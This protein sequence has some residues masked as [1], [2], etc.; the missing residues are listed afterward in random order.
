[1]LVYSDLIRLLVSKVILAFVAMKAFCQ[2]F[3]LN[4]EKL[5][6]NHCCQ[7]LDMKFNAFAAVTQRNLSLFWKFYANVLLEA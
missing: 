1:M 2:N 6:Q 7:K 5:Q 3:T 4:S